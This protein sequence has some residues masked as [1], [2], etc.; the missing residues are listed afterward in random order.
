MKKNFPAVIFLVSIALIFTTLNLV[1]IIGALEAWRTIKLFAP[2]PGPGYLVATG[3][4]W[5]IGG[6]IILIG[7]IKKQYWA[8][9]TTANAVGLYFLYFWIDRLY[10]QLPAT[11]SNDLFMI[12]LSLTLF[13]SMLFA[14]SKAK[15]NFI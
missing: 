11:R 13:F 7:L 2:N 10:I 3:A 14:V 9:I 4:F 1:R 6:C 12:G 15:Q 8:P 5:F